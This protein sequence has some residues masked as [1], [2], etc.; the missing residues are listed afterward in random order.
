MLT[1]K[2]NVQLWAAL[3][4]AYITLHWLRVRNKKSSLTHYRYQ[5]TDGSISVQ[6]HP[7]PQRG[8]ENNSGVDE[9]VSLSLSHD[10]EPLKRLK[11]TTNLFC[12]IPSVLEIK[13]D[14]VACQFASVSPL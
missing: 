1:S 9:R 14:C 2:E 4:W 8:N 6:F 3:W 13:E 11:P 10:L 12:A 5:L 7:A